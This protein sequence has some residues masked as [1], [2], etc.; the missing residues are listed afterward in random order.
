MSASDYVEVRD[1]PRHH[2]R[3]ENEYVRVYEALIY[4]AIPMFVQW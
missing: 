1:E 3:F 2:H 4:P